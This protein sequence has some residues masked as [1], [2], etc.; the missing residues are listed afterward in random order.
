MSERNLELVAQLAAART[1]GDVERMVHATTS[2]L[3]VDATRRIFDPASFTGHDGLREFIA[4]LEEAWLE[5]QIKIH[6]LIEVGD[7][8]V[9]LID[10]KSVGRTSGVVIE[11]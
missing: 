6:E 1:T 10:L 5:Q 9:A 3:V 2:D 11:A 4:S 7:Q 8:V